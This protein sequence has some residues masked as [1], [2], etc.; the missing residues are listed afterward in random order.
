MWDEPKEPEDADDQGWSSYENELQ[1]WLLNRPIKL[2]DVPFGGY[3]GGLE[4]RNHVVKL[5]G[6]TVQVVVDVT[7]IQL[8]RHFSSRRRRVCRVI[9]IIG[10]W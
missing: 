1:H 8:V 6:R 2:P 4:D 3:P 10:T 5:R 9:M 7:E